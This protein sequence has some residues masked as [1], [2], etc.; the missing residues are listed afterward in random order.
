[1]KARVLTAVAAFALA[2]AAPLVTLHHLSGGPPIV[3][4]VTW[5]QHINILTS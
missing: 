1:M 4:V 3:E 2:G 5:V